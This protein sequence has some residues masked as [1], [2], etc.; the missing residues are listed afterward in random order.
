MLEHFVHAFVEV[1]GVL[2]GLVGER[3]ARRASPDHLLRFCIEEI[4][5]QGTHFVGLDGRGGV[6]K[7]AAES[8]AATSSEPVVERVQGLLILSRLDG[9][10]LDISSRGNFCP[11]LCCQSAV[12]CTLDAVDQE[13]VFR[14]DL[15]PS[16]GLVLA[17]VCT[18]VVVGLNVLSERT[19][20]V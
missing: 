9:K 1:L 14:L 10:D 16:V 7:S 2:V 6:A 8:P 3:I 19:S 18:V 5:Y 15:F 17:K 4:D 12:H 13:P 20:V 11:T